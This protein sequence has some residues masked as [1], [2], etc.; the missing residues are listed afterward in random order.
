MIMNIIQS[1]AASFLCSVTRWTWTEQTQKKHVLCR[2]LFL[3]E[4]Y[5][6]VQLPNTVTSLKS[7]GL[8]KSDM[9]RYLHMPR[10]RSQLSLGCQ[11]HS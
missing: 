2:V 11:I 6:Q 5:Q 9:W 10:P 7:V 1:Q 8:K 3:S 4:S